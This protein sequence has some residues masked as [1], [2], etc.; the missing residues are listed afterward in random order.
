MNS[1]WHKTETE[2]DAA[3]CNFI[4]NANDP[5]PDINLWNEPIRHDFKQLTK[6]YNAW[7]EWKKS[8]ELS[9][10]KA[11]DHRSS[12]VDTNSC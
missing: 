2:L 8:Q 7:Y 6:A 5:I 10:E 3:L 4:N 11:I 12:S 1:N 9:N